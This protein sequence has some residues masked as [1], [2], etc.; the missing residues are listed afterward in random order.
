V[1]GSGYL[2]NKVKEMEGGY[3]EAIG[4]REFRPVQAKAESKIIREYDY[5]F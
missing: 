5:D 3:L 1:S 2:F 4:Y